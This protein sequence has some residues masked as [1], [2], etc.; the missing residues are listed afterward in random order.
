MENFTYQVP[1]KVVFGQDAES[2]CG[3]LIKEAGGTKVLVHFG[4]HSAVKSGLIDRVCKTLTDSGIKYV[5]LGGVVPN[6][7]LSLVR[8]GIQLC[9][10]EKVDFV[11]AVGGGS[12]IDSSKA[13]CYGLGNDFDVWE[14]YEKKATPTKFFPLGTIV[15][16]AAAGS[17]T[18]NSSV[19]TNGKEKRGTNYEMSRPLFSIMNPE[20]T[21]TLPIHQTMCGCVDIMMHT[22]ERWFG[23]DG[24]YSELTDSIA[25]G[26]LS[27]V[28]E[29]ALILKE[30]P[31]DYEARAEIM[32]AGS[33]SHN[34]LTGCGNGIGDW[35]CHQLGHELSG[36]FGY[37]HGATLASI[38]GTWARYVYKEHPERFAKLA[39]DVLGIVPAEQKENEDLY[40][41]DLTTEEIESIALE[42]IS[43]MED[44]F[45]SLDMPTS[46]HELG[47]ELTDAQIDQLAINCSF[48]KTRTIGQFKQLDVND[49]RQIYSKAR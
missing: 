28:M 19:I 17:E 42:G 8:E 40:E 49:M 47:T 24:K 9:K 15:T 18:S 38:W 4:G 20:L 2:Q 16:I 43:A 44:F 10:A 41:D 21:K 12:V 31:K 14:I 6:P 39:C 11:L 22:L 35:S 29:N 34:G 33:L 3:E 27:T 36:M 13:I 23:A 48:N 37:T 25:E 30:T 26:L 32:W 1:T 7:Q 45:K 5:K 46:I